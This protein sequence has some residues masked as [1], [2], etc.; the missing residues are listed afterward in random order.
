ML[1]AGN[2]TFAAKETSVVPNG[3]RELMEGGILGSVVGDALGV[4]GEF[5]SREKLRA[6]PITNMRGGG[7]HGQL[8]GTWSD[9]TSMV[10]ATADS[11]IHHG[12]DYEDQMRR[13]AE[14]LWEAKYTA[15]DEV[16]DVGG[17]TRSA[18]FRYGKGTPAQACGERSEFSCGNGSLMRILPTALY[19]VG[20]N[21][22]VQLDDRTADSIH[23]TSMCTHAH[24]RCQMAC[25]IYCAVVFRLCSKGALHSAV[26]EG[27]DAALAYY[28]G[29]QRFEAVYEDFESLRTVETWPEEQVESTGYVL[30]TL[31]AALWC[32]LTTE[33]YASCVL[34]AVNL[35]SDT[36]TTAAVAGGLAGLWYGEKMIPK[37]W[38]A[39]TAKYDEIKAMC[40]ALYESVTAEYIH[41]RVE[42]YPSAEK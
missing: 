39:A 33:D 18:I 19:L 24:L 5:L 35:G 20:L 30:H 15:R 11:L 21:D 42:Q 3:L 40:H 8:P 37:A 10:L 36:D 2:D 25:G 17:A 38:R 4:P 41:S 26:K 28:K 22:D 23:G 9:D 6:H 31:Q 29:N 34:K 16:L 13:F 12:I 14:W 7:V 27:I 1:M 32:L